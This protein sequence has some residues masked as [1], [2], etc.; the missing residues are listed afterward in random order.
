MVTAVD[1]QDHSKKLEAL[2]HVDILFTMC[3]DGSGSFEKLFSGDTYQ[4]FESLKELTQIVKNNNLNKI[5]L[6]EC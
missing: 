1:I 5:V 4:Q 2:L 3:E 6:D